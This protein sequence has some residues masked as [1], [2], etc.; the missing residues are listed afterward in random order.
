MDNP[1]RLALPIMNRNGTITGVYSKIRTVVIQIHEISYNRLFLVTERDDE[2]VH[3]V[4]RIIFMMCH[5]T[6][7]PPISTNAFSRWTVSSASRVPI[8]PAR[9]ATFI[10]L[11]PAVSS[12][13][14]TE[15]PSAP[16]RG[17]LGKHDQSH[18]R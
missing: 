5:R 13:E 7:L 10:E 12:L 11:R 8:P 15:R 6:G 9:I 18:G 3:S 17:S 14:P 2:L 1:G 4:C 16:H